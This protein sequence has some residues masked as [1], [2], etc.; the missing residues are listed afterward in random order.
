MVFRDFVEQHHVLTGFKSLVHMVEAL[1]HFR[2]LFRLLFLCGF[3]FLAESF[4]FCFC[5]FDG[6]CRGRFRYFFYL[7]LLRLFLFFRDV[8]LGDAPLFEAADVHAGEFLA[9]RDDGPAL[10]I[11]DGSRRFHPGFELTNRQ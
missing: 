9:F 10:R 6:L 4:F 5:R 3:F 1:L 7:G 8:H 2:E 11:E